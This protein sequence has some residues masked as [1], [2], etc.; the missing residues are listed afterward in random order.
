ML[1]I[2]DQMLIHGLNSGYCLFINKNP[3][4]GTQPSSLAYVPFVTVF[5]VQQHGGGVATHTLRPA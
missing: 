4:I 2:L 5:I 1:N 3:C